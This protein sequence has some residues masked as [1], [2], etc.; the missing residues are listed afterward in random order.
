M[1]EKQK[2]TL[3][4]PQ[5]LH[6]KLKIRAAVETEAMS[7]IVERAVAFY[8]DRSD[9]VD[10]HLD[11]PHGGTHRVYAC[12]SCQSPSTIREGELVQLNPSPSILDDNALSIERAK[13]LTA[14]QSSESQGGELIPC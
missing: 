13:T 14:Q 5:P 12:P 11:A 4:L 7:S 3:Y 8:L 2:V 6:R 9:I 1:Q 10:E